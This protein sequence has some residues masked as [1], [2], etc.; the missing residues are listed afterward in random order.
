MKRLALMSRLSST[1]YLVVFLSISFFFVSD[2][3]A[4]NNYLKGKPIKKIM[5]FMTWKTQ[6]SCECSTGD[7]RSGYGVLEFGD[8]CQHS[9]SGQFSGGRLVKGKYLWDNGASSYDGQLEKG[10]PHGSGTMMKV[11]GTRIVGSFLNG[12]V[13]GK[14]TIYHNDGAIEE[15][16]FDESGKLNGQGSYLWTRG[17]FRNSRFIG[18]FDGGQFDGFGEMTINVNPN[19]PASTGVGTDGSECEVEWPY[20]GN[21]DRYVGEWEN[22]SFKGYGVYYSKDNDIIKSGFWTRD[23]DGKLIVQQMEE[24]EVLAMINQK[25]RQNYQPQ[26][27]SFAMNKAAKI[28][29]SEQDIKNRI[30]SELQQSQD[31][32]APEFTVEASIEEEPDIFGAM[33]TMLNIKWDIDTMEARFQENVLGNYESGSYLF[34]EASNVQNLLSSIHNAIRNEEISRYIEQTDDIKINIFASSDKTKLRGKKYEGEYGEDLSKEMYEIT[35]Q[36]SNFN[37]NRI[38]KAVFVESLKKNNYI[39]DN[40]TL[41]YV[42]ARGAQFYFEERVPELRSD[43][44]HYRIITKEYKNDIGPAYRKL[45]IEMKI[46]LPKTKKDFTPGELIDPVAVKSKI[47]LGDKNPNAVGIVISNYDYESK[48]TVSTGLRDGKLMEEYFRRSMG[49]DNIYYFDNLS[50]TKLQNFFRRKIHE[51]PLSGKDVYLYIS[52]HGSHMGGKIPVIQ[53]IDAEYEEGLVIDSIYATLG[54][55]EKKIN[56]S[57][58]FFDCCYTLEGKADL[59]QENVLKP[60]YACK[61]LVSLHATSGNIS[62]TYDEKKYSLFTYYLC[63]GIQEQQGTGQLRILDLYKYVSEQVPLQANKLSDNRHQIPYIFPEAGGEDPL[64]KRV[65][66]SYKN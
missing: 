5:G 59:V 13:N 49:I 24:G 50:T 56:S 30:T 51:L 10:L 66:V 7:C 41:A 26:Q 1:P 48:K 61:K 17:K 60:I 44:T 20:M 37:F 11:D 32:T 4:Q 16:Y 9:F 40:S 53:G 64:L 35:R 14:A 15:G 52:S 58:V 25:Y 39:T 55:M 27:Q 45:A 6:K 33:E 19:E 47:P 54:R 34:S 31:S 63:K 18:N 8:N 46:K 29:Q 36:D 38:G 21:N 22:C 28:S 62:Y 42:R 3:F 12:N 2:G 57:T 43:I 23:S 65:I